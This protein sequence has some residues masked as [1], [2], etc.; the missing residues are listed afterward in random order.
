MFGL[1]TTPRGSPAARSR[2]DVATGGKRM[3]TRRG[4]RSLPVVGFLA[5]L[6]LASVTRAEDRVIP[7]DQLPKAVLSA[8]KVKFPGAKIQQATEETEGEK[9]VYS[10]EMKHRSHD[11]DVTFKDDGTVVVVETAVTKKEVPK[12]VLQ[13][14]AK[15]YPGASLRGAGAVKKG[16]EVNKT[17]DYY[18]FYLVTADN[19]PR[20]VKVDPK[21]KV[22]EDPFRRLR[23]VQPQQP[24]SRAPGSRGSMTRNDSQAVAR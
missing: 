9:P 18:A 11:L 24:L 3:T 2:P 1:M 12:V 22:L 7:V 6:G 10:L 21:G 14:V 23:R 20:P 17:A 16:P 8:A 5:L 13:A 4:M 19:K 15:Q